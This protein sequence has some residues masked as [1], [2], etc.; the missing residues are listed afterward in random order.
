[1]STAHQTQNRNRLTRYA[2]V[3]LLAT[4]A[5]VLAATTGVPSNGTPTI[6]EAASS[7]A[8]SITHSAAAPPMLTFP[9][10]RGQYNIAVYYDDPTVPV[11]D[12][13]ASVTLPKATG[14]ACTVTYLLTRSPEAPNNSGPVPAWVKRSGPEP[15]FITVDPKGANYRQDNNESVN[16]LAL[17]LVAT[18]SGETPA[19]ANLDFTIAV[20]HRPTVKTLRLNRPDDPNGYRPGET[21]V[22]TIW[23]HSPTTGVDQAVSLKPGQQADPYL[24]LGIDGSIRKAILLPRKESD[25]RHQFRFG[26]TVAETDQDPNGISIAADALRNGDRIEATN[27]PSVITVGSIIPNTVANSPDHRIPGPTLDFDRDGLIEISNAQQLD[28]IRHDTDRRGNIDGVPSAAGASA[29]FANGGFPDYRG[30]AYGTG[31]RNGK[32][33]GYELTADLTLTDDFTPI[34]RYNAVLEGNGHTITNLSVAGGKGMFGT[35]KYHSEIRN[36]GFINPQVSGADRAKPPFQNVGVIAGDNRGDISNVYVVNGAVRGQAN[37]GI[38]AGRHQRGDISNLYVTGTVTATRDTAVVGTIVGF[39]GGTIRDGYSRSN[40]TTS[41]G[42]HP[43]FVIVVGRQTVAIYNVYEEDNAVPVNAPRNPF[44]TKTTREL[45]VGNLPEWNTDIWDFGDACQY[46]V[47]KTGGHQPE[48]Q[49]ARGN[50]CFQ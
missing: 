40:L 47:L 46:P 11:E 10:A 50:A 32:C 26:Y 19:T 17:R 18:D 9:P 45:K 42:T 37:V 25:P 30:S 7:P 16:S 36:L 12:N 41:D 22:A 39:A 44:T 6:T 27:A 13:K 29:Y 4:L 20:H 43:G 8:I 24:D 1:M 35:T 3:P 34:I 48:R 2:L 38:L 31:C 15:G 33:I 21:I 14:G 5:L 28:L 49:A 23:F